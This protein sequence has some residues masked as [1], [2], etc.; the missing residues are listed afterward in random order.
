MSRCVIQKNFRLIYF[1]DPARFIIRKMIL[2]RDFVHAIIFFIS[3]FVIAILFCLLLSS[4]GD[5]TVIYVNW[6]ETVWTIVPC[7]ILLILAIPR[8]ILLY[9]RD[10]TRHLSDTMRIIGRQ[11]YW[12]YSTKT[13]AVDRY[14][15]GGPLRLLSVDNSVHLTNR[16]LG[17][18]TSGDV[19]HSWALPRLG[20][21]VDAVPGRVR[22]SVIDPLF[23]GVFYGQCREICGTNH[24]F[25]PIKLSF[26]PI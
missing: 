20:V 7:I 23:S 1:K 26:S 22:Y 19:L 4:M 21:K 5:R 3:I 13:R 2:F 17:L 14:I 11:W 8:L 25:I 9:I 10:R 12:T 15:R 6:L 16:T 18:V 24:S